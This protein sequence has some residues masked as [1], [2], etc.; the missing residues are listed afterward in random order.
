L[1]QRAAGEVDKLQYDLA[2]SLENLEI[3]MKKN[4][5]K[6]NTGKLLWKTPG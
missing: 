3:Y 4:L 2:D 5:E 1:D 6:D